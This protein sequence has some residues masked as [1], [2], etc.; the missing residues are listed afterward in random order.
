MIDDLDLRM[1]DPEQLRRAINVVPQDP[2][3]MPGAVRLKVDP[4]YLASDEQI[5]RALD[6]VGLGKLV[7]ENGGLDQ[8]LDDATLSTGQRQ[9]FCLARAILK[10]SN[11]LI[12]DEAMSRYSCIDIVVSVPQLICCL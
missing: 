9:L 6:I 7:E 10:K 1:I 5:L 11:I 4:W 12:L 3:L 2:F 8:E